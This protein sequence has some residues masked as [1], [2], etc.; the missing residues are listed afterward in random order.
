[1]ETK[2]WPRRRVKAAFALILAMLWAPLGYA[3]FDQSHAAW[4]ALLKRHVR[5]SPGGTAS[6]VRYAGIKT[7]QSQLESYLES[8]SAVAPQEYQQWTKGQQLAFLINAYNAFTVE[9]ILTR[10]PDLAS[11]KDL[12]G[13][14]QSPWKKKFFTLLGVTRSLDEIEHEMIRAPGVFDDPR[15]HFAV[16]CASIGCPMLRN[17]AFTAERVESQ[18]DDAERRFLSDR[19]RNRYDAGSGTLKVSKIFDWYRKDFEAGHKGTHSL[20]SFFAQHADLLADQPNA[21][22]RLRAG[23]YRL[24]FL[25]YDWALNGTR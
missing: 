16:V 7:E 10:Y 17:E 15:I 13:L 14:L 1:M 6:T 25:P 23:D 22:A 19:D 5:L 12:G 21:Q 3:A 24:D 9:L 4:D 20:K 2:A 18:L 8:L 11:I